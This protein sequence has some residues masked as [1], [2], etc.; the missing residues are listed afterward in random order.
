MEG[1][2]RVYYSGGWLE[3]LRKNTKLFV[4]VADLRVEIRN[5]NSGP[6]NMKQEC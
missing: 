6:L 1:S 3:G 4:M 2:G 5:L